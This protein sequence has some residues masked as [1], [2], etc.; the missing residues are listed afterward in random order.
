VEA[1][2][3]CPVNWQKM[4]PKTLKSEQ[5]KQLSAFVAQRLLQPTG[6]MGQLLCCC[7]V[8]WRLRLMLASS[9]LIARVLE[10]MFQQMD[11]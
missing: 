1:S 8:P 3:L 11:C 2:D 10:L 7:P 6:M 5:A 4:R 9:L